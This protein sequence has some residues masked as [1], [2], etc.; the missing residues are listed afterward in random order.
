M[1]QIAKEYLVLFSAITAAEESL[2]QL[3][4]RLIKAQQQA[5]EIYME[6]DEESASGL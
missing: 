2:T 5:E 4:Q 3:R 1:Q 6:D